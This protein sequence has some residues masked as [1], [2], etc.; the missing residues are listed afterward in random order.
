MFS[1]FSF[2]T[3]LNSTVITAAGHLRWPK[4]FVERMLA[5]AASG[6]ALCSVILNGTSNVGVI[7]ICNERVFWKFLFK[8]SIDLLPLLL[9]IFL[10]ECI[11]L[12]KVCLSLNF[13]LSFR[14][15]Y[16]LE[17]ESIKCL[18]RQ[19][20]CYTGFLSRQYNYWNL[21]P[22]LHTILFLLAI[23]VYKYSSILWG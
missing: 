23:S 5:G 6:F 11:G 18:W 21:Y 19:I 9:C 4:H 3:M 2:E 10:Q 20:L 17:N 8:L 15:Y 1:C 22:K 13:A 14:G 7:H 12:W 16:I